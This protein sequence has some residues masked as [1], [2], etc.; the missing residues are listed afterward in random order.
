MSCRASVTVR[1]IYIGLDGKG[2]ELGCC[3]APTASLGAVFSVIVNN[4]CS[5][6]GSHSGCI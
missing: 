5:W 3:R 2:I 6:S 1:E 4:T